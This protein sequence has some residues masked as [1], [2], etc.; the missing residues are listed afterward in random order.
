MFT[1]YENGG[2]VIIVQPEGELHKIRG[3]E[4]ENLESELETLLK[5]PSVTTIIVDLTAVS[6]V[7]SGG[8]GPLVEGHRHM[9]ERA[10]RFI[11]I[12][13]PGSAARKLF[14]ITKLDQALVVKDSME[15]ALR[16]ID[17]HRP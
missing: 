9:L 2:T 15:E 3:Q 1:R 10:G 12:A 4:L 13:T 14:E 5:R 11:V 17:A 16:E 7:N 8:I 6:R